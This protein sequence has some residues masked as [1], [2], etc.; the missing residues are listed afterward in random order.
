MMTCLR[1]ELL[2][3]RIEPT[4]VIPEVARSVGERARSAWLRFMRLSSNNLGD[5]F[6]AMAM[7]SVIDY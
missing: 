4:P 1:L 3:D 2:K 5:V 6:A 7:E